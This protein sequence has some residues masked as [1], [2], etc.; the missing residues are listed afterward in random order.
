MLQW[1][2]KFH[3]FAEITEFNESFAPY[4]KNS[5]VNLSGS[6]IYSLPTSEIRYWLEGVNYK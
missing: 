1:F 3:E 2:I 4:R 5:I 6:K